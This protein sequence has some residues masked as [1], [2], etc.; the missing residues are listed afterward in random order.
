MFVP[1]LVGSRSSWF[2]GLGPGG[3]VLLVIS[4]RGLAKLAPAL[5]VACMAEGL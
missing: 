4:R 2:L 5:E 1:H 3:E